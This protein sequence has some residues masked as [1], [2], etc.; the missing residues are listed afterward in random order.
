MLSPY[1]MFRRRMSTESGIS[2]NIASVKRVAAMKATARVI[3]IVAGTI[4]VVV[5]IYK[6]STVG[7]VDVA[8]V[9]DPVVMPVRSPVMPSPSE[10]AKETHRIANS[11]QNSRCGNIES[12]VPI[13]S[14]PSDQGRTVHNPGIVF[15]NVNNFGIG[16]R[17]H[18]CLSLL[19]D[20]LLCRAV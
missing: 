11:K 9:N 2:A 4:G 18:N 3:E 10:A 12:R 1:P 20:I 17:D 8:V 5:A 16:W 7:Y 14:R 19:R 15:G 13:P 6:S